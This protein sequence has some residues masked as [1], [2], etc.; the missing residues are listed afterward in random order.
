MPPSC[1][2][3]WVHPDRKCSNMQACTPHTVLWVQ[4]VGSFLVAGAI[5]ILAWR[6]SRGQLEVA[7]EKL[8]YDL[9]DRRYE[10]FK[11]FQD[12]IV[13][14]IL[15]ENYEATHRQAVNTLATSRFLVNEQLQASLRAVRDEA[16][17]LYAERASLRDPLAWSDQKDRLHRQI[18][19][20]STIMALTDRVEP[21]AKLFE[22]YL[23]LN[24]FSRKPMRIAWARGAVLLL[25]QRFAAA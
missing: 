14:V 4:A 25:R 11:S 3:L 1:I 18:V 19:V 15:D 21:L 20:T 5:G 13:L 9:Y 22:P 6:V 23:K 12:L 10:I 7:R 16:A 17:T 24:D 2:W 8:R